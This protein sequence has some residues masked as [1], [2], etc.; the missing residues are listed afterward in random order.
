MS[1]VK[2]YINNSVTDSPLGTPGVDWVEVNNTIDL[3]VF[4]NGGVGVENGEP[5][6][7]DEQLNRAAVQLNPS[8]DVEPAHYFLMAVSLG[9]L[10]EIYLAGNQNKQY[11]FCASF[12]GAT[13]TEPQLEAWDNES[14]N[15]YSDVGLGGGVPSVSWYKAV[16]TKSALPGVNWVGTKLAGNSS[17]HIL[18]LNEGNGALS[19]AT[20]LYFNFKITIPAGYLTP[21]VHT[22]VL[23][24]TYTTN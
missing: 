5:I 2:L 10:L 4:S 11:V 18:L 12:D 14:M 6:P 7:T 3:F 8:V 24:I 20:D 21:A 1:N 15:S 23:V 9:V 19:I 16:A 22:P 13:A 17:S